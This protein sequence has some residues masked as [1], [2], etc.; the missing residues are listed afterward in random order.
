MA[1]TK[2]NILDTIV[3]CGSV[4]DEQKIPF[5]ERWLV[6]PALLCGLIKKSDLKD[7]SLSGDGTSIMRNGRMGIIDRFTLYM[8]NNLTIGTDGAD[9]VYNCIAG[10]PSAITF[11]SQLTENETLKNPDDFGDLMRGLQ[12]Y[13]YNVNKPDAMAYLYVKK[14]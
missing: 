8:S 10:H 14:G 3:D 9:T 13:G 7:A 5:T 2:A 1:V 4:L 11:A 6:L 12:V